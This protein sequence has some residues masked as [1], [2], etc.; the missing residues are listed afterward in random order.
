MGLGVKFADAFLKVSVDDKKVNKALRNLQRR[1]DAVGQTMQR[2]G[3]AGAGLGLAIAAA[4]ALAVN[5]FVGFDDQMR[6]VQAVSSATAEEFQQLTEEAKRLGATTSFSASEVAAGMAELGR[7]GFDPTQI[8]TATESVL[9][10]SR[11]TGTELPRATEIAGAALRGFSLEADQMGRV[12]DVLS[13]TA[14]GTAQTLEDLFE[15]LKPVAPL[16]AAAGESLEDT[17]AAI[18]LL[19]NAGIKGSLAGNALGRAFKNLASSAK[20]ADLKQLGVDAVDSEGNLRPLIDIIA[21]LD[22]ATAGFG[23]ADRLAT[24]ENLFGRGQAAALKLSEASRGSFEVLAES[25]RNSQGAAAE[26]AAAMDAGLGGSIR[27]L[28]SSIEGVAIALGEALA[29]MLDQAATSIGEVAGEVNEWIAENGDL[30]AGIAIAVASI[31]AISSALVAA[32]IV[33]SS[34]GAI[35]GSLTGLVTLLTT[36]FTVITTVV[37]AVVGA[38]GFVPLAL[39]AVV[40]G[41]SYLLGF[42]SPTLKLF[43]A[44]GDMASWVAGKLS[45]VL[46]GTIGWLVEKLKAFLGWIGKAT[47]GL[48]GFGDEAETTAKKTDGLAESVKPQNVPADKPESA[49]AKIEPP[50]TAKLPVA[51]SMAEIKLRNKAEKD[52]KKEAEAR[53]EAQRREAEA[54]KQRAESLADSVLTPAERLTE[55]LEEFDKIESEGLLGEETLARLREQARDEAAESEAAA[56]RENTKEATT[57]DSTG[58]F[59]PAAIASLLRGSASS[60]EER[61]AESSEQTATNT[62]AIATGISK[63]TTSTTPLKTGP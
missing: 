45:D 25:I 8:L 6:S 15:G 63:M 10:L 53:A 31:S 50:A 7:A 52:A 30:V 55:Q 11:A 12:S 3:K 17:S 26:T 33:V 13:A 58:I 21:D 36:A 56:L 39:L 32:G 35:I 59:N 43:G 1:F 16:A 5:A 37:G 47:A 9:S 54:L 60:E 19:A 27:R 41:I 29:P 38:I 20:Q 61:I 28:W 51:G 24:F 2:V 34:V 40:E 14:N 48:L 57:I 4:G 42:G 49:I 22:K 18:G 23:E 46:G 62:K 44:I